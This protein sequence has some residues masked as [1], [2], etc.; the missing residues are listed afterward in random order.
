MT[1]EFGFDNLFMTK[2]LLEGYFDKAAKDL[3]DY[4]EF[5]DAKV[6]IFKQLHIFTMFASLL[7]KLPI[8]NDL[9][10]FAIFDIEALHLSILKL[11]FRYK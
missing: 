1:S 10:F 9:L 11:H 4:F 6:A 3:R 5:L 7:I 8:E 2:A